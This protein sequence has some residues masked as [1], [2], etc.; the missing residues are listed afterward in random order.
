MFRDSVFDA[1]NA[2]AIV[3]PPERR[4]YYEGSITGPIGHS[5]RTSFLLALDEDL[6][7]QQGVVDGAA[8]AA[9]E[10]LGFGRCPANRSQPNPSLLRLRTHLPRLLQRRPVL[11]R[12]LLRTSLIENQ[13]VSGTTPSQRRHR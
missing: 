10:S 7:N 2:F 9:A 12:L 6:N 11:D 4:Q 5:K 1:S 13:N 8:I 3:K